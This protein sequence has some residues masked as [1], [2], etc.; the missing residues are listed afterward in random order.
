MGISIWVLRKKY[1][2]I[3]ASFRENVYTPAVETMKSIFEDFAGDLF[4]EEYKALIA[5]MKEQKYWYLVF[6]LR[7]PFG[8]KLAPAPRFTHG[9]PS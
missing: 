1:T 9:C 7:H 6:S 8:I 2:S 4:A 5:W 3:T